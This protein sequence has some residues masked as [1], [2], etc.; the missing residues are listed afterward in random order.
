MFK[1]LMTISFTSKRLTKITGTSKYDHQTKLSSGFCAIQPVNDL[2]LLGTGVLGQVA[3]M[4]SVK[5]DIIVSD[6]IIANSKEYVVKSV[7]DF[8]YGYAQ[9]LEIILAEQK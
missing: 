3:K 1:D 7:Q 8:N 2:Q 4:Y 6:K 9:H 5:V